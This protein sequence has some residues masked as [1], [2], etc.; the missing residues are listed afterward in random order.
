MKNK[1]K[2]QSA[3]ILLG[4]S[5]LTPFLQGIGTVAAADESKNKASN[6]VNT[7]A[8]KKSNFG[9]FAFFRDVFFKIFFSG[10]T[11]VPADPVKKPVVYSISLSS[12][13]N[14]VSTIY[15]K[16]IEEAVKA[17]LKKEIEREIKGNNDQILDIDKE[18][19]KRLSEMSEEEKIKR[20]VKEV[21]QKNYYTL[22]ANYTVF[23]S[24]KEKMANKCQERLEKN[25][26]ELEGT[27][28]TL[29]AQIEV[30]KNKVPNFKEIPNK[31]SKKEELS[32]D[33]KNLNE[34]SEEASGVENSLRELKEELESIKMG[35]YSASI[36]Q[37]MYENELYKAFEISRRKGNNKAILNGG[38]YFKEIVGF[39]ESYFRENF[40]KFKDCFEEDEEGNVIIRNLL[41]GRKFC[42][43]KFEQ[44]SLGK[45]K[46]QV[47]NKNKSE[48]KGS[49]SIIGINKGLKEASVDLVN[50]VDVSYLQA[51]EKN[52][53]SLFVIASNFNCV[54][55]L[56]A[57]DDVEEKFIVN[58][59]YD[60]TQG[61][62]GALPGAAGTILRHYG[63]NKEK[64]PKDVSKWR[65]KSDGEQQVNL[66]EG[67]GIKTKNGYILDNIDNILK[68]TERLEKGDENLKNKFKIGYHGNVQVTANKVDFS[69]GAVSF[70]YNENQKINQ[71]YVAAVSLG[72]HDIRAI[73]N[74][75]LAE[76]R[77]NYFK[78]L[79]KE[80]KEECLATNFEFCKKVLTDLAKQ[81]TKL[82]YESIFKSAVA[83]GVKKV[84]LPLLGCGV[85]E[86]DYHWVID[87]I[88]ENK[89]FIEDNGLE[90][91]LNVSSAGAN[92]ENLD[93]Y[94]EVAK[95]TLGS[96]NKSRGEF[97]IYDEI[98]G[99][100]EDI[101]G[102]ILKKL[103]QG[104]Q[105]AGIAVAGANGGAN[106]DNKGFFSKIL[107]FFTL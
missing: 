5:V 79:S 23:S 85:F 16:D 24:E 72:D 26:K 76:K 70:M 15:D 37:D 87:A 90:V 59:L 10:N 22:V 57:S 12:P 35:H 89:E 42:A 66:L 63:V 19:N 91:I 52:R 56:S 55:T 62:A 41:N 30:L 47:S 86:N 61:P 73:L 7:G 94:K 48:Q 93:F 46:E 27:L 6:E 100:V 74:K 20:R 104:S 17:T 28:I 53:D 99:K 84:Y 103:E 51:L 98:D 54:E 77:K 102:K 105:N 8:V 32:E 49:I 92:E 107:E 44:I 13:E 36:N 11:K 97:K 69:N 95:L 39:S 18:V 88:N 67:L 33:E 45:A 4:T 9:L 3:L 31:I 2:D 101:G 82:N 60:P 83:K 38:D 106:I 68:I 21:V 75:S 14:F 40:S 25:I 80:E 78:G 71:A 96:N 64:F 34:K 50:K 65:Q 81:I 43:G 58:Y 1:N 29:K